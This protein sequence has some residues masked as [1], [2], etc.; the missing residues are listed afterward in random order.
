MDAIQDAFPDVDFDGTSTSF[1]KELLFYVRKM[2]MMGTGFDAENMYAMVS[3]SVRNDRDFATS[4]SIAPKPNNVKK[5]VFSTSPRTE[6][7]MNIY[8]RGLLMNL[9]PF[10]RHLDTTDDL[11]RELMFI[12][13][14][15]SGGLYASVHDLSD[16]CT[17][18]EEYTCL[19]DEL[20]VRIVLHHFGVC[21]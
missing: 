7:E 15:I 2:S 8:R 13:S 3:C 16:R 4:K 18:L 1:R 21:M 11:V 6:E 19:E 12:H 9:M 10:I 17:C 20:A 5:S 14:G